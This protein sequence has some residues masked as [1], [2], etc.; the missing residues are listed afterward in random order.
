MDR[1]TS[2]GKSVF[3]ARVDHAL[4][5]YGYLTDEFNMAHFEVG[6]QTQ[7]TPQQDSAQNEGRESDMVN[8]DQP[9]LNMNPPPEIARETDAQSFDDRWTQEQE[10]AAQDH[11][12]GD[13]YER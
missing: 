5:R 3:D 2:L 9:Q 13:D 12:R 8:S 4:D 1:P 11:E 7:D 10:N 6:A